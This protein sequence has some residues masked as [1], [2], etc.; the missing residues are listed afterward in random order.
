MNAEK[1]MEE[2]KEIIKAA[3]KK[4]IILRTIGAV[5]FRLHCPDSSDYFTRLNRVLTDIDFVTLHEFN[6]HLDALLTQFGW[7]SGN[8][9]WNQKEFALMYN[10]RTFEKSGIKMDIFFD[11][12]CMCHKINLRDRL[13]IDSFTIPLADMLLEK[14]QIVKINEKDVKDVII[15]LKDHEIGI[16]EN[17]ETINADF[18]ANLLSKDWGFYYTVTENLKKIRHH[19][20]ENYPIFPLTEREDVKLKIDRL[21]DTIEKKPKTLGWKMRAKI[22]PRKQW[23]TDVEETLR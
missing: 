20:L 12:L 10:R 23:Y 13:K 6:E 17:R 3:E 21:L 22:G 11:E 1:T 15:L 8:W 2:C 5:A 16:A 18:V 9:V 7:N 4:G 14:M 19:F